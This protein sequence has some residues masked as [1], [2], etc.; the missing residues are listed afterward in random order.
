MFPD[1]SFYIGRGTRSRAF[2]FSRGSNR[3]AG[4]WS[5][6]QAWPE[7]AIKV[8]LIDCGDAH[9]AALYERDLQIKWEGDARCL[10]AGIGGGCVPGRAGALG[11][12]PL[13]RREWQQKKYVDRYRL[14]AAKKKAR[15][16]AM[17]EAERAAY[18]KAKYQRE[19]KRLL[20]KAGRG[21]TSPA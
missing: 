19:R 12:P 3:N 11:L 4:H 13:P 1:G 6:I 2:D 10:C 18:Y 7:R 5:A 17:P 21:S 15:V 20:L 8:A 14:N 16:A 9:R